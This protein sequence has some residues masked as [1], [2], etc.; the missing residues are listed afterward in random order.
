VSGYLNAIQPHTATI[1]LA[2]ERLVVERARLG[3]HLLLARVAGEAD[4][5]L[6]RADVA[7]AARHVRSY[8]E[9]AGLGDACAH[10]TGA[11]MFLSF[12]SLS[13]FNAPTFLLPFM[14][15]KPGKSPPAPAYDYPDRGFA[16]WVHRLASRY[17]W[18]RH[19]VMNELSPEEVMAYL[20]EILVSEHYEYE[21]VRVLSEV[22]YKY[23]KGAKKMKYRPLPMPAWMAGRTGE[24]KKMRIHKRMLPMGDVVRLSADAV[25]G[26]DAQ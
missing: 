10:A 11:E 12:L 18:T 7:L 19:Y 22:A 24:P 2:G 16:V 5:A 26:R 21:A 9:L 4:A 13:A 3:L 23:D 17:G 25:P 15:Q 14:T 6:Q 8:L 20:Q 1:N